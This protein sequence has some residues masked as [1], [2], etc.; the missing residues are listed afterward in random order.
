MGLSRHVQD[1]LEVQGRSLEMQL[2]TLLLQGWKLGNLA[3]LNT[4]AAGML[5]TI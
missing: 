4:F 3:R 2:A 5:V 1:P